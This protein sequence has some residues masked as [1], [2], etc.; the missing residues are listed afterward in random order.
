MRRFGLGW[1]AYVTNS[2]MSVAARRRSHSPA[3]IESARSSG[4]T[5]GR[6]TPV[7]N[8]AVKGWEYQSGRIDHD[9]GES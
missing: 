1:R 6:D 3:A 8:R 4:E 9:V 2:S 5:L 7:S